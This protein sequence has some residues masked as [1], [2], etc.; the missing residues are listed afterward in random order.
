[1]INSKSRRFSFRCSN[2][3]CKKIFEYTFDTA[4]EIDDVVEGE[5]YFECTCG[6]DSN[7]LT[8]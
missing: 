1:M 4:E 5:F 2:E 8:S 3:D 7:L 6:G